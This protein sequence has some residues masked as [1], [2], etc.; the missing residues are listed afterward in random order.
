MSVTVAGASGGAVTPAPSPAPPPPPPP[1]SGPT[2]NDTL[3]VFITQPTG[4]ATVGGTAWVVMWVEGTT[5]SSNAFTLS[6][7]GAVVGSQTTAAR[8]PVVIPWPTTSNGTHTL[9]ATVRDAAGRTG[10]TSMPVTV[11]N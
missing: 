8:G 7:D 5:G 3:K 2:A 4:G 9:T 1:P 6:V 11:R 10:R